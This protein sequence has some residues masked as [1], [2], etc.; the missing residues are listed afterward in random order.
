MNVKFQPMLV[1]ISNEQTGGL[2]DMSI[3]KNKNVFQCNQIF[4]NNA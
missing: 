2:V 4:R 3:S 1:Y